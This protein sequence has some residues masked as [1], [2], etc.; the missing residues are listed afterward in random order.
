MPIG[1]MTRIF[2]QSAEG[3]TY[4]RNAAYVQVL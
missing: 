2:H 3:I 4:A 1:L